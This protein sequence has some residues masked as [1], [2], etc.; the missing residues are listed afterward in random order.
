[1][2]RLKGEIR[3]RFNLISDK[4]FKI[5]EQNRENLMKIGWN[6]RKLL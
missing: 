5:F 3:N 1:M 6:I 4:R 2:V